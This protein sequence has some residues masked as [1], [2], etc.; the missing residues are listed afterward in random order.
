MAEADYL[1]AAIPPTYRILGIRLKAFSIGH[2]MLLR[3]FGNP[4]VAEREGKD[5]KIL[6]EHL[7]MGVFFC[8]HTY[9][10]ALEK[11]QEPDFQEKITAWLI[12]IGPY[13]FQAKALEF[14]EYIAA[15]SI[16][17]KLHPPEDDPRMPGAPFIQRVRLLLMGKLNYSIMEANNCSWGKAVHDYF[18]WLEMEHA[19]KIF[20]DQET[21]YSH[22][23]TSDEM[24]EACLK[25]AGPGAV[26]ILPDQ[27]TERAGG[28]WIP[29]AP[30]PDGMEDFL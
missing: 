22:L 24:L 4:F 14:A 30:V 11:M 17:P 23:A 9:E 12:E 15:H 16:W 2:L 3:H 20:N 25:M 29:Q 5:E 19:A 21:D 27:G 10:E 26:A 28:D 8:S 6:P 13:D 1:E 18:A 7:T